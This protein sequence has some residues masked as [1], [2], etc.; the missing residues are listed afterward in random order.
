MQKREKQLL[1]VVVVMVGLLGV[2]WAAG[3]LWS[4][5]TTRVNRITKLT[6]D[7]EKK[8]TEI[9]RGKQ[10]ANRL[11]NWEKQSLPSDF[12]KARSLYSDWL[13]KTVEEAGLKEPNVEPVQ[14]TP[15][16][17]KMAAAR[18]A[19]STQRQIVYQ[20]MPYT[21][22][23][24][25]TSAQVTKFLHVFYTS[26]HLHL[27]RSLTLTP[28]K[29]DLLDVKLSIDALALPTADRVD[30]L[31]NA[32]IESLPGGKLEDYE[33]VIT[34]RKLFAAYTPPAPPKP[35]R[36][37]K[38]KTVDPAVD[39]ARFAKVTAIVTDPVLVVWIHVETTGKLFKL[40]EGQ[41]FDLGD[42]RRGKVHRIHLASRLVDV[43]LN[44]EKFQVG[45][46]QKLTEGKP[47][48]AE[49]ASR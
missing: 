41:E 1:A 24:K 3:S 23:G 10:A 28:Q 19:R 33:K 36:E 31:A 8:K 46:G 27:I 43:E 34:E 20:K 7:S 18:G 26:G 4:A 5:H 38:P 42:D 37:E 17:L 6:S 15:T 25:A 47:L 40:A 45:L 35:A 30:A 22:R 48:G 2:Y 29:D 11:A 49:T 9:L 21:V 32:P 44:N 13:R 16:F 39:P 12:E 14:S